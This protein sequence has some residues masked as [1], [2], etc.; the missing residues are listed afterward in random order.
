MNN[1][2]SKLLY[3]SYGII[4]G[5]PVLRCLKE[6]E[7]TQWLSR[8]ELEELQWERLKAVLEHAHQHVPFYRRR[9]EEA[10]LSP[11]DVNEPSDLAGVPPLTRDDIN[12][13]FGELSAS[14]STGRFEKATTSGSTGDPRTVLRG[15]LSTAYNR[16][17]LYRGHRWF[18]VDVG[19]REARIWGVPLS[20][21][22]RYR[23]ALKDFLMNRRR[24]SAYSLSEE[25][26]QGFLSRIRRFAPTHLYG[27]PTGLHE[28][29]R[30]LLDR[31]IEGAALGLKMVK[32]TSETV[33]AHHRE[34]IH[35]AFGC[36]V[37]NEYGCAETGIMGFQ[38]PHGNLHVP[39]EC[40]FVEIEPLA[41]AVGLDGGGRVLV[42]DLHNY[43]MPI[44]RYDLGDVASWGG[45]ACECGRSLPILGSV[46][47]RSCDFIETPDGTKVHT[48]M[49]GYTFTG[50]RAKGCEVKC[51]QAVLNAERDII[52]RVVKG[53]HFDQREFLKALEQLRSIL[54]PDFSIRHE[55]VNDIKR[56]SSGKFQYFIAEWQPRP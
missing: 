16:A 37:I 8:G 44:I 34:T 9:F 46:H 43:V 39:V 36:P 19:E 26:M 14:T 48:V 6:L 3:R 56:S 24:L 1:R 52:I 2:L 41:E 53:R 11:Q 45:E 50:L 42:T 21:M 33:Y 13:H 32:I 55:Y 18:G 49:L 29:A 20:A 12:I 51:F 25:A 15:R 22:G 17:A 5:E 4:R 30:F 54:G 47:G 38:C 27:Y 35:S 23:E 40:V 10:G 31:R 28:F 7:R